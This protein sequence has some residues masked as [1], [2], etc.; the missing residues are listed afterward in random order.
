[1]GSLERCG[2]GEAVV[3]NSAQ[4]ARH[5]RPGH[6]ARLPRVSSGHLESCH[7]QSRHLGAPCHRL[8]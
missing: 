6:T 2:C 3:Q 5:R 8:R 4:R 7:V 1:L